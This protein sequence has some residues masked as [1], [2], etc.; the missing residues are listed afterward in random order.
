MIQFKNNIFMRLFF[1]V[2]SAF[3]CLKPKSIFLIIDVK[4][5]PESNYLY[6][7]YSSRFFTN[8][9][10]EM[11]STVTTEFLKSAIDNDKANIVVKQ[12]KEIINA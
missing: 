11:F 9:A 4:K 5:L 1:K 2:R 3:V 12:A 7:L 10:I 6:E 8:K